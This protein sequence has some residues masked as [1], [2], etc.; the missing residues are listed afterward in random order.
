M[1]ESL[2]KCLVITHKNSQFGQIESRHHTNRFPPTGSLLEGKSQIPL[3]QENLGW[4]TIQNLARFMGLNGFF[5]ASHFGNYF[6]S[7]KNMQNHSGPVVPLRP[8][9][10]HGLVVGWWTKSFSHQTCQG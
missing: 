5:R 2:M 8:D 1:A 7:Q 4:Q 10:P 6:C 9:H 3:F